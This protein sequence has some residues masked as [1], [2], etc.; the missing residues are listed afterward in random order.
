MPGNFFDSNVLLYIASNDEKANQAEAALAKGGAISVQVLNEV[1]NVARRKM[2][3]SW[4]DT[5]A[6]LLLLRGLLEVRPVTLE[7]HETGLLI[8]ERYKLSIFD[9][10]IAAV[11]LQAGCDT[12]LSEGM[13][14]GL[15]LKEGLRISNPFRK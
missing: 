14:H 3:M 10:M 12:L 13:E 6:F 1:A 5:R 15:V 9:A 4:A 2:G 7:T 8:A 11:A